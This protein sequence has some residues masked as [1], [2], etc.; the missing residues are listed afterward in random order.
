[1]NSFT[2]HSHKHPPYNIDMT[3]ELKANEQRI[4][5]E[6]ISQLEQGTAPWVKPWDAS[7]S[8]PK[9]ATSGKPYRGMNIINLWLEQQISGHDG[10]LGY[11]TPKKAIELGGNIKGCK[12]SWVYFQKPVTRTNDEGEEHTFWLPRRWY[13]VIPV[14]TITGLPEKFY[15]KPE[16]T[17]T[18][19]LTEDL[20]EAVGVN[21]TYG[22]TRA[23]Y[24]PA[25][26]A[27]E[28]PNLSDFE[29]RD[30]FLATAFH[31]AIH[32]TGAKQRLNREEFENYAF[33]ELVAEL[34]AAFLC[35][36]FGVTGKTQHPEYIGAWITKLKDD[37]NILFR[38]S[39]LASQAVTYILDGM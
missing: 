16:I 10:S 33:E 1:M 32:A 36:H 28:M 18:D 9:N 27:I 7:G 5:N 26:D 12:C 37:G 3:K 19:T 38:A 39:S 4:L 6:I 8:M 14:A 35:A 31:E 22:S 25:R 29:S 15:E 30:A 21:V 24:I 17:V 20:F 34:G 11:I 2:H 13:K 23:C